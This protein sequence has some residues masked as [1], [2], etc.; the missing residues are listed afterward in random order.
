MSSR[1]LATLVAGSMA[2]AL[3][4]AGLMW[5]ASVGASP[6]RHLAKQTIPAT[7]AAGPTQTGSGLATGDPRH[8]HRPFVPPP[9]RFVF[10]RL[11]TSTG[12]FSA[13]DESQSSGHAAHPGRS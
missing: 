5:S 1:L 10:A 8:V 13:Q 11:S 4:G 7:E 3:T 6:G 2:C 9:C 12:A